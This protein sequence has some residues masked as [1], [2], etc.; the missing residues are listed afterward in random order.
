MG[1]SAS[2]AGRPID[3]R[4]ERSRTDAIVGEVRG[5]QS[6]TES[7]GAQSPTY[8]VWTF[9]VE[10]HDHAGNRLPPVPVEMRSRSFE[11]FLNDGDRV[12]VPGDWQEGQIVQA[13]RVRNLTT[14]A[15][16]RTKAAVN[17][18]SMVKAVVL[19]A[20]LLAFF[21]F[22]KMAYDNF[23]RTRNVNPIPRPRVIGAADFVNGQTM[24]LRAAPGAMSS[25]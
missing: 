6:R 14:G 4:I 11:G 25:T 20:L 9:R 15:T 5:F 7:R 2:T 19:I 21:L 22:M 3:S 16:V 12:E 24:A 13:R 1:A 10:R 23:L 17:W 18:K 8:I